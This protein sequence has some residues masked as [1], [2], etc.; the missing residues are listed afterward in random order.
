MRKNL[1]NTLV[2]ATLVIAGGAQA[3]LV[4][5]FDGAGAGAAQSITE[6]DWSA[7]TY[8]ALDGN[9]AVADYLNAGGVGTHAFTGFMHAKMNDSNLPTGYEITLVAQ[10]TEVITSVFLIPG[11][12]N[13]ATFQTTGSGWIEMYYGPTNSVD[14]SGS[15]FNDGTLI[16]RGTGVTNL[17]GGASTGGFTTYT[18]IPDQTF[19]GAPTNKYGTQMT[20]KGDSTQDDLK[21]GTTSI[22]LDPNFFKTTTTGFSM[23]FGSLAMG[24]PIT[25]VDPSDCFTI[26][27]GNAVNVGDANT[28]ASCSTTHTANTPYSGQ[29]EVD[30]YVPVVGTVNGKITK[31]GTVWIPSGKDFV[32]KTDV[33]AAVSG[34]YVPDSIP[35]PTTLALLGLGLLGLGFSVSRRRS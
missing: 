33:N 15:G 17:T 13:I 9:K 34:F 8:L 28:S 1:L 22:Q 14:V 6:F 4:F 24:L 31:P 21:I 23:A 7:S 10:F 11:Y 25:V 29:A 3:A 30:G 2:A 32:A 26:T 16:L 35:E 19:D 20:I 5:D 12:G 18:T 27:P